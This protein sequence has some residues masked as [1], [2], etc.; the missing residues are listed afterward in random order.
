MTAAYKT[1]LVIW[2]N[3]PTEDIA[4]YGALKTLRTWEEQGRARLAQV[5]VE[6]LPL[7]EARSDPTWNEDIEDLWEQSEDT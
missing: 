2:S 5:C 1:T 7:A 4:S 6:K 3:E